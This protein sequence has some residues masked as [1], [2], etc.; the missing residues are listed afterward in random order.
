MQMDTMDCNNAGGYHGTIQSR[1]SDQVNKT[2]N[3]L[4]L[5]TP[6]T[7]ERAGWALS[8]RDLDHWSD[9]LASRLLSVGVVAG[10]RVG[11]CAERSASAIAAMVAIAKI[12]ACYVPLSPEYPRSRLD[13]MIEDAAISV[14]FMASAAVDV[15]CGSGLKILPLEDS[16]S[17]GEEELESVLE[18]GQGEDPA[19]ILYTSGSTGRPKGVVV[20]H[21]SILRLVSPKNTYCQFD[22]QRCFLQL[23]PLS[24][25][26]ATFEIWGAL[27]NGACCVVVPGRV[28]PS[29][30]RL[31]EILAEGITTLWLTSS[32]YNTIIS[33]AP[34]SLRSV[35]Q[36]LIGGEALS[37]THVRKG[38]DALPDTQII[39][40]YGPTENTT[41]T[42]A[43]PIPRNFPGT[44]KKIPIGFPIHAT[45]CEVFDSELK[46][47]ADG[48][49]GEL[50]AFGDGVALGYLNR[51]DLTAERFLELECR[52]GVTRRGYRTG[53]IVIRLENGCYDYLGRNDM[54]V[55]IDG[56]RIE[57]Q[58]I[59][60]FINQLEQV[61]DARVL[62]KAGPQGQ[63]RLVAYIVGVGELDPGAIRSCV[64][65]EFPAFMVPHFIVPL[66]K[67]PKNQNGKL[68]EACL[69]D[70]FVS[71]QS[72]AGASQQ[73]ANCW[74]KILGRSV[75]ENDNFLDAGG[76][77]LEALRLTELFEKEFERDLQATFVFEYPSVR[78]QAQFFAQDNSQPAAEIGSISRSGVG[79]QDIAVIGIAC[80][81]PG[82]NNL[83]EYW[84]NLVNGRE[85]ISF[86]TEETLSSEVDEAE[87]NHPNYVRARGIVEDC[88]QFDAAFFGISPAEAAIMDPQQRI[89]LQLA[90]HALEDAGCKP[91]DET[92]RTGVFAGMNWA[93]Y[94][95]QY[96]LNNEEVK[97]KFGLFNASLANESDFL[98]SRISYKLN[99]TGPSVN[100]YTACSTGLVAISQ[101]CTSIERGD[102]EM[103]LAGGVSITTP[104][105]SGYM[106][107]EGSMLSKDGHCRPFD[108]AATGTT[109]N[110]GAGF[111]VL[112]RL[113]LALRDGD[114]I[115]AVTKGFA[116][117]NDG[118]NKASFT[119][120]SVAGQVAVYN[121]AL[122]KAAVS[123]ESIGLIETHGTATP[124]GDPI[125][126]TALNRSYGGGRRGESCVL[127]S[128]KSNIG[129]TIHA[130]GVA[131]FIKIV[132]AVN[133]GLIPPTLHFENPNPKLELE[134]TPFYVNK[135][136]LDW[137]SEGP[138]RAAVSSLGVGGTNAHIIV[139][140]F[141]SPLQVP[142][143]SAGKDSATPHPGF[144]VLLSAKSK[145]ALENQV[146]NYQRFFETQPAGY[147]VADA[148]YTSRV[149]RQ[150]FPYRAAVTGTTAAELADKLADKKRFATGRAKNV[151]GS[152]QGFMFSGQG[153]QRQ[154]MGHWL[155]EQNEDFRGM[156]DRGSKIVL[157]Q[158][159]FDPRSIITDG[160]KHQ[161]INLDVNQT[162]IAQ[163]LL[164]LFEYGLA[165]Y[166]QS[167]GFQPDFLIG[168]SI[169]EFAAAALA[170]IF[171]FDDA[172]KLVAAR[173]A[174][175]QSMPPG[176][177]LAVKAGPDEVD[178][179]LA[180]G[181]GLAA[182]NAPDRIVLSGPEDIIQAAMEKL[183][184]AKIASSILHTSHAFHSE[185]MD[186]IIAGIEEL[187]ASIKK[188]PPT[189]PVFS[190]AT[191]E[192]MTD[193]QATDP[194]YWAMQ[195]R[196]P[197]LFADAVTAT[198]EYYQGQAIALVEVGPGVALSSLLACQN[199]EAKNTVIPA[200]TG[201]AVGEEFVQEFSQCIN[202]LWASGFKVDWA[203]HFSG[204]NVQKTR[205]PGYAF[206]RDKH[207]LSLSKEDAA[208]PQIS[209][210][211]V[212]TAS[213][214]QLIAPIQEVT[215][216]TEQHRQAMERKLREL[217]E[218]VTGSDLGDVEADDHFSEAGLDSLLLTQV[219]TAIEQEFAIGLTFR[220]LVEDY[221][222]IGELSDFVAS[223]VAPEKS[224]V[225]VPAAGEGIPVSQGM[226]PQIPPA[227]V[228]STS[229][230]AVQQLFQQQLQIM[231]L[232]LQVLG[233]AAPSVMPAIQ[234]TVASENTAEST[235]VAKEDGADKKVARQTPGTRI[236]REKLGVELTRAQQLWIDEVMDSYQKKYAGSKK[237]TQTHR[238]YLADPRTVSGFNPEWK[239]I[240]FPIVTERSKGSKLW[241]IDGNELIDTSNG[242]G[243]IF[244][245]HSP[246]F[247]TDAVKQQLDLGIETGPQS[248]LAGE[249]ARLFCELTGNE[250][251][252]FASTGSEAVVG[253]IRLARTVTGRKKVAMFGGSYHGITDEVI[254]RAGKDYQAL[255]AAPGISRETT[256]NMLV[257][258][259]AD[260]ESLEVLKKLGPELAAVLVEPVQS[261]M[262]EF[263]DQ[264]Y[265]KEIRS[266]TQ[267]CGAAMILDEVVTGFRVAAGGIRERFDIDADLG[268]YGKVV[269]GGYPIGI[270]GGKAKFM[271]ALDGGH[272][273]YGDDS[274]PE[275][276]VTFFAG[277]F[278]RH[279]LALTAA[280]AVLD[281]IKADGP[282]LYEG[283]EKKTSLMTA[284]AKSFI[285]Q[286]KC[287]VSFESFTSL[288]YVSVPESA[289][290]GHMLFLLMTLEGIHIQQYRPNFLTTEHNKEDVDKILIAFKK[291]LAKLISNGLI[292][293]DMVVAKRFLNEKSRIPKGARLGKNAQAEPAYFL[294]D[295]D[296]NGKYIEVGRP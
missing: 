49:K 209:A 204:I 290:W 83:E 192:L 8:Y 224:Q 223:E 245:G 216:S 240:V 90:Q 71:K 16:P 162:K 265:L 19:Y 295:P 63:Q 171:S 203:S 178:D 139:E 272:W 109:F 222:S 207:W 232:Q 190:T 89:M 59:E 180:T 239:E 80:R 167:C 158:Q 150:H 65:D 267:D 287:E 61:A 86:F 226:P 62:V 94:F 179:L 122:A 77:S 221:T 40:G 29:Y 108:A 157:Q 78:R 103:A 31:A 113:D 76:T 155:Y 1:F 284:E 132:M 24:F 2:P 112:K 85:T 251:C 252:T 43:Y 22:D 147:S 131:S 211:P 276:G 291:S 88:D 3:K 34:E 249:V 28:M 169:G 202:G 138:R 82:A 127:G 214:Q 5:R 181:L 12:S 120:P 84:D 50:I 263:N 247:I 164:F 278:V 189:L 183:T 60:V 134:K 32:L 218:D 53:D 269:G 27:L 135:K 114:N 292:E 233:G 279:P 273:Q 242:F 4:C 6:A 253:A 25:D 174:L 56:H 48:T 99:L 133:R 15:M 38:L 198:R 219:A 264:N 172:V 152:V 14:A 126:V 212:N 215:M 248:P 213:P 168:H 165:R 97:R 266:I 67:L 156:V 39:N 137:N 142:S 96:V 104:V 255:P 91:G 244:F 201:S 227:F 153:S 160:G 144:S 151:T 13:L 30:E 256:S 184:K 81:F 75:G 217:L 280:K 293:G 149:A 261:R 35:K 55:K 200:A 185:M 274:I 93:R 277:T 288:F 241:D 268:T 115:Y 57:P 259:W 182:V 145:Q 23:A 146:A 37:V 271:D 69:P 121:S 196:Q 11:L 119:A 170:G 68:D 296:N 188:H 123:P 206:Q 289:H 237:Y 243:P 231:Q 42:V 140:Q 281:R 130:A 225:Q 194:A 250:R 229:D 235:L 246:D 166:L 41:F 176:K 107:Q 52:D 70:P 47:V 10:D 220:H 129:H 238:K 197:V 191:G 18:P 205:L 141:K 193:Q 117:N 125:E 26:A 159:G 110:D 101:A 7:P 148:A 282:S 258:P 286:M 230:D 102:C 143:E 17:P 199:A 285:E 187:A 175:M 124:L 210:A 118:G 186:P 136:L 234:P 92:L 9:S 236:V 260:P 33:D 111:V 283:L 79:Q 262:P 173:G 36:L 154:L 72:V 73:V 257:L 64:A 44:L 100:V 46:P 208:T 58:E 195:L 275:A 161:D 106:Y 98:S 254:N 95:Q 105:N 163:P 51:P 66:E 228:A 128:V 45:Y 74:L 270:I 21:C 177:M 87:R 294:E 116:V 54:Q 20:P